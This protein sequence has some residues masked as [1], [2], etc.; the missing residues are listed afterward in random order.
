MFDDAK[1]LPQY[2]GCL[3]A[4]Q[5]A[6][7]MNAA[8]QNAKRLFNS[9][10]ILFEHEDY[11]S[12]VSLAVLAIEEAGKCSILRS[13]ALAKDCISLKEAWKEYRTHVKKTRTCDLIRCIRG[14][15]IK[16]QDF[17]ELFDKTNSFPYLLDQIKQVGFYTDCLGKM[18]WSI[19]VD[20]IDKNFAEKVLH[21][22][23]FHCLS[24][25]NITE[26]EINLW[27]E[28]LSP[29]WMKSMDE[30]KQ[31]LLL[32]RRRMREAGLITKP[33]HFDEFVSLGWK[34]G[35]PNE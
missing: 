19:P 12:S 10:R 34:I 23:Q 18:H 2:K 24:D 15:T 5:I 7:G 33:D 4:A 26:K 3:T 27:I 21:T 6:D 32:W 28:C 17:K 9:A 22:A 13:L 25:K 14:K 20:V 35:E 30:M 11:P 29:V 1:H 8:I 31:G 16:L